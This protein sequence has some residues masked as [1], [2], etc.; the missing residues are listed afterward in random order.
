MKNAEMTT[1]EKHRLHVCNDNGK[2]MFFTKMGYKLSN[3]S[4]SNL[5]N[6]SYIILF[7]IIVHY[8][9]SRS[10]FHKC[11]GLHPSRYHLDPVFQVQW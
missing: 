5:L 11:H 4:E 1:Y 8:F 10:T 9:S 7:I 2:P 6:I 3:D